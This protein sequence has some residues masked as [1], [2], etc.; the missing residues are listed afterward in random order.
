MMDLSDFAQPQTVPGKLQIVVM[1]AASGGN[2]IGMYQ[3]RLG[4]CKTSFTQHNLSQVAYQLVSGLRCVEVS[5]E[6]V[7]IEL[8]GDSS[9]RCG[10]RPGCV[11]INLRES[12][13]QL[14]QLSGRKGITAFQSEME[15][16]M[17]FVPES[18]SPARW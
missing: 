16:Q 13:E 9:L 2:L 14:F 15:S 3:T 11:V 4:E 7:L 12:L 10:H 6:Q 18:S 17:V 5:I 1:R 8:F